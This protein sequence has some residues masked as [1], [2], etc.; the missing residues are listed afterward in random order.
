VN[1]FDKYAELIAKYLAGEALPGEEQELFAWTE[2]EAA[3]QTFFEEMVK[4]WT[5]T[6]SAAASPFETDIEQAWAKVDA[7]TQSSPGE[8]PGVQP[9][10][11]S[12]K[13]VSLSK[14]VRRWSIAAAIL[15]TVGVVG[16][17]LAKKPANQPQIVEYRTL[18]KEKR[19]I[20]LPDSSHV[21]LNEN[22]RVVYL[23]KFEQRKVTLEGEAFFQVE[24]IE[25]RPFEITSGEA[26]TTVLGT[27]FNV[28]AYPVE[29]KI[30]VTVKTG[31]VALT[32]SKREEAPVLLEAGEAGIFDKKEEKV[33]VSARKIEN[34][35]AW[36]TQ[37]LSFNETQMKDII[38]TLNRYFDVQIEVEN[39]MILECHYSSAFPQ[40]DI[41]NILTVIGGTV[42]FEYSK[43]GDRYLLIGKGCE[44]DN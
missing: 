6:E 40:P 8:V 15:V 13:I 17:W 25:E 33:I 24:R 28:R 37:L 7:Y 26:T 35:D 16:W 43:D 3:N 20:V 34:A 10:I 38:E 2:A 21:W 31:K 4:T 22:S 36:K 44:P 32:V 42:G 1:H 41:E 11:P 23:S 39:P 14:N 29:D 12:P 5:L 19:E 30:E 18:E 9:L 27:S